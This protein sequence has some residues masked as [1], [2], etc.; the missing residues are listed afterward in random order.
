MSIHGLDD[1][2]RV[3]Q[4]ASWDDAS[5]RLIAAS[6]LKGTARDWHFAFG[7][8]YSTWATWSAA[9]W[10]TFC[11][12]LSLI[13]WQEQVMRVTQA[14]SESLHQ[15]AFAK[16][17]IIE[18]CPV[19]LSEA[20]KIDYLLHGLRE[21]HIL[22][23]IAANRPPTVTEFISTCTSFDECTTSARQSKPVTICWF[24]VAAYAT[25]LCR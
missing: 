5:T 14:P 1:V 12:E 18:R 24:C 21:Q 23:A 17:K 7:N 6:K 9:L 22:A 16:L 25:L 2:R 3:Q 10:D 13:E 11:A 4:L 15:Y 19:N 8:Q 20:Q